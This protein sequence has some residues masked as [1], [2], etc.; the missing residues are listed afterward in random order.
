M[1]ISFTPLAESHFP[2]L[3]K[4][5]E[6]HHVKAWWDQ[7]I[8]W[9]SELIQK[10]Y[11]DYVTDYKLEKGQLKA[12]QAYIIYVDNTPIG[13]I[14]IY[15]AYDFERS[16][17]LSDLPSN[18]AAFD[19]FIGEVIYVDRGIGSKAINQFLREYA[20]SYDYVFAD[21]DSANLAAIRAYEKAGFKKIK[22]QSDTGEI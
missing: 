11:I 1:N 5:L 19:V 3:L 7:N 10:K 4:W 17:P 14:Q 16:K 13:Y 2:L 12:L 18:L 22:A 8:Q 6:S 9:T 15:N 21:P 20:S